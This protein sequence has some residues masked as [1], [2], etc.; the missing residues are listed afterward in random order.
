MLR[1]TNRTTLDTTR[2]A[3]TAALVVT[4]AMLLFGAA[5]EMAAIVV[6]QNTAIGTPSCTGATTS[7]NTIQ[8]AVSAAPSGAT[9]QI[10]PGNYAEQVVI[11]TTLTLKGVTD[12]TGNA[13]AAVVVV[14]STF[15]GGQFT[16]I[17]IQA[18]G[19]TLLNIGVDGTNTLSSCDFGPTITGILFDAGSSGTLKEVA[20]RNQNISNGSGGYCNGGTPVLSNSASSVTITDSSVRN[21]DSVGIDLTTTSSVTVKTTTVAPVYEASSENFPNCIYANAPTV[22]VSSN[23]VSRRTSGVYITTTVS[24]T[25][26]NNTII[27]FGTFETGY[28]FICF[29]TCTG[30]TVSENQI[31]N[32][33]VGATMKT[34]GETGSIDFENNSINGT[35]TAVYLFLQPNNTV[36]NNTITDSGVGVYGVTGNT[37]TGNTYRTVTTLTQP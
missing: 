9:I 11:A 30:I 23:T 32:T 7:Y 17:D 33:A 13:G 5:P 14:P 16:Q 8:S 29:P 18:S 21:Y 36:S 24:G 26:S 20:L 25:V 27:G 15:T 12:T 28:G 34:S 10:C 19:V 35:G 37:V 4:L 1:L 3:I 6:D 31:F 22:Q 2:D